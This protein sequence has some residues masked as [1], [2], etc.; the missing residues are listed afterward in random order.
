[1]SGVRQAQLAAATSALH[2]SPS[3]STA[4]NA[5]IVL[6]HVCNAVWLQ[7]AP[8]L[9]ERSDGIS[10]VEN[11]V[12]GGHAIERSIRYREALGFQ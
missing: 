9:C 6:D 2:C 1:M 7:H 8:E 11:G 3:G 10:D 12:A 4:V 5:K